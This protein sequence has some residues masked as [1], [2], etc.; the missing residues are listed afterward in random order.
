MS[1]P[2]PS[3]VAFAILVAIAI[4]LLGG[5]AA[6]TVR[7]AETSDFRCFYEAGRIV[8]Q[9]QDPY[10]VATWTAATM[11]DPSRLP[12]CPRTTFAYPLWT[13]M[14]FAPISVLPI[15]GA[16][17]LWEAVLLACVLAALVMLARAWTLGAAA[18]L[19][20]GVVLWSQPMFSAIANAQLGPVVLLGVAGAAYALERRRTRSAGVAFLLLLLK[21][22]MVLF[23]LAGLP[24]LARSR[25]FF[26]S[27]VALVV[28]LFGASL[29]LVPSWPADLFLVITS[30]QLLAD[31]DLS[32][33]W[34]LVDVLGLPAAIGLI[35]SLVATIAFAAA[36][37]WRVLRPAALAAALVAASFLITPY[38]RAHDEL[39]LAACWAATLA[40][41]E[42]AQG[43]R[44]T[45]LF[46]GTVGIALV[47]PWALTVL[48]LAGLPLAWY[49]LVPV[50]TA[51]LTAYAL[52]DAASSDTAQPLG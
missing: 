17:G 31:R 30:Q 41:A 15:Q 18:P 21:P 52:R 51:V 4:L 25:A 43:S 40:L 7:D 50:S 10:D 20:I 12:P 45:A 39:V 3:G 16:I 24:L 47:L 32:T 29:V 13:A 36:V 44:R 46:A 5:R 49:A 23:V 48:S 1:R 6:V 28:A 22:N 8:R 19:L 38:T 26:F 2:R 42:R 9:G 27:C 35:A 34:S 37:R 11:N 33:L 14:V